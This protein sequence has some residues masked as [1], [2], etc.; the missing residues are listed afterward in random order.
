MSEKIKEISQRISNG[1][2]YID[3]SDYDIHFDGWITEDNYEDIIKLIQL[4]IIKGGEVKPL[5][6]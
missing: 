2:D 1:G 3:V 5:G 6:E 4:V